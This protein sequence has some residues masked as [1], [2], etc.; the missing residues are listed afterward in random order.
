[1][2]K[3]WSIILSCVFVLSALLLVGCG[4]NDKP[5]DGK[6]QINF[7]YW[8]SPA[9]VKVYKELIK[10]YE[11]LNPDV[12]ISDTHHESTQYMTKFQNE[13][14]KPDVFFMPDT[15]FLMWA[16]S[17][18]MLEL[19]DYATEAEIAS[20]WET[21]INE[22]YYDRDSY[23]LGK[24]SGAHL[25]GFPKDLG[26]YTLAYNKKVLDAQIAA[27]GLNKADVYAKLDPRTPMTWEEFATLCQ[28]LTADQVA[29]EE[30]RTSSRRIYGIPYYEMD[31]AIY[32]SNASYFKNNATTCGIDDNFIQAIVYQIQ[33]ATKYDVM[34]D[35]NTSGGVNAYSMFEGGRCIFTWVGPWDNA[36]F[37]TNEDLDYDLIPVPFN[38]NV[39]G[40]ES[41]TFVGSM[42]YGVSAKSKV[43]AE[44]V[45]FAKWLSMSNV[46]QEK[47]MYLGQQVPNIKA[48][49]EAYVSDNGNWATTNVRPV[50]RSV[51]IDVM[52][53]HT[54]CLGLYAK[55]G[56]TDVVSGQT[57]ALY[58]TYNSTWKDNFTA[59]MASV[60]MW[61][62]AKEEDIRAALLAYV[63]RY[64]HD[65]DEMN[66]DWKG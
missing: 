17:G 46:C 28:Q 55:E 11:D 63:D 48:L 9:E 1:M 40:A 41:I 59:Y 14:T 56:K 13:R 62:M 20:L 43:K 15:D 64:Q 52:D 45:A 6:T 10:T 37:W 12:I 21:G 61:K 23:T 8:G 2:K 22:Y 27:N 35:A 26:P 49:K 36:D 60:E 30:K 7:W 47:A 29:T 50:N 5:A 33:L 38:G 16:D 3:I 34:P 58:Y 4:G 54:D 42:C 39:Q 18:V 25:Y 32:S 53:G 65:L 66:S 57:R 19:D 24:S 44:A 31:A 51:F